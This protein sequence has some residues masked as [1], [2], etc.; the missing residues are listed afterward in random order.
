MNGVWL[1][2]VLAVAIPIW[3]IRSGANRPKEKVGEKEEPPAASINLDLINIRTEHSRRRFANEGASGWG[4][5]HH[6][7]TDAHGHCDG[8]GP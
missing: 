1:F 2:I 5:H 3:I 6:G 4:L 7:L 8:D